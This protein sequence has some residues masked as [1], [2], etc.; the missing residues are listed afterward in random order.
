MPSKSFGVKQLNLIGST[1]LT[2]TIE[3]P[4][5]INL[6]ANTVAIS[7]DLNV[8]RNVNVLG[9]VTATDFNSL[10][11]ISKKI[12]ILPVDNALKITSELGGV[13]FNWKES[14]NPSI[15][16]IAQEVEKVLPELVSTGEYK[17]VNYNGIIGVLI[18]AVKELKYEIEEIKK[19]INS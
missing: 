2:P 13:R 4:N 10:S 7:T 17:T 14:G 19:K 12:N 8:N 5:N 1:G 16:V 3:S 6:N 9:I 15:G 11:D 18:E